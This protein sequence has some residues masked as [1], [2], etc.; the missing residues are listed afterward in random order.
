MPTYQPS[1]MGGRA[2]SRLRST[3]QPLRQTANPRLQVNYSTKRFGWRFLPVSLGFSYL[4]WQ[5]LHWIHPEQI[6]NLPLTDS[7]GPFILG[8]FLTSYFL[9][10]FMTKNHLISLI[11]SL[12]LTLP[13]LLKLQQVVLNFP[14]ILIISLFFLIWLIT[15]HIFQKSKS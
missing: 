9:C 13:I 11:I 7:Y 1:V 14:T 3:S 8:I 6:R 2:K 15:Y 10:R 4:T 12:W 5:L